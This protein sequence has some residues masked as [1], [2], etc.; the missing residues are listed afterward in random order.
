MNTEKNKILIKKFEE[1]GLEKKIISLAE[2]AAKLGHY[3]Q[4]IG[5]L[6]NLL[7]MGGKDKKFIAELAIK[8]QKELTSLENSKSSK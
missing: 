7:Q 1:A 4:S 8:Y 3:D 2:K 6:D 5:L